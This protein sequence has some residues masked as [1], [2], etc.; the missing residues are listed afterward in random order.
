MCYVCEKRK[1]LMR[2]T[3]VVSVIF[4]LCGA[5]ALAAED[6][7]PASAPLEEIL[8]AA[9][10][11][12]RAGDDERADALLAAAAE[13]FADDELWAKY[14]AG[15]YVR[16]ERF[17]EALAV[18][19]GWLAEHAGDADW[20]YYRSRLL[21]E[22][23]R[24]DEALATLDELLAAGAEPVREAD[25]CFDKGDILCGGDEPDYEGAAAAYEAGLA[26]VDPW[27]RLEYPDVFY[28]LACSYAR[29]GDGGKALDC[30]RGA[31]DADPLF[32]REAPTD[33]DLASL[34]DNPAFEDLIAR[35]EARAAE[36]EIEYMTVKPGEAAPDFT[37]TDIYG[38]EH[39]LADFRGK[40]VVL[41]IWATWCPPCRNEI[42]DLI[43]FARDHDGEAVVLSISVDEPGEDV[44]GFAEELGID[45]VVLLDDGEA[46]EEYLRVGEGIPQTYFIDENG[47]V[48]GHIYGSAG[49]D[50]FEERLQRLASP[51]GE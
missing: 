34:R 47:I 7:D 10:S 2:K 31:L 14:R 20:L 8:T 29:L 1:V 51:D 30:L 3:I 24:D 15:R 38:A 23:G 17:D 41:N 28:N 22:L 32:V 18:A 42:P 13:R 25:Y 16:E 11:A 35:A 27:D 4:A 9:E 45:Y 44:A 6:I 33:D 26:R 19:D 5:A 40:P 48:R 46:A 39:S 50:V 12:S 49:R 37:L 43:E 21:R 36:A